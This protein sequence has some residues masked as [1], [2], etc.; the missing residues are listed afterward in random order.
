MRNGAKMW[1][2]LSL[3][4]SNYGYSVVLDVT[5]HVELDSLE[6]EFMV[7]ELKGKLP[8]IAYYPCKII[9]NDIWDVTVSSVDYERVRNHLKDFYVK[10]PSDQIIELISGRRDPN[11]IFSSVFSGT[12][13]N[14]GKEKDLTNM[15]MILT[16]QLVL[17]GHAMRNDQWERKLGILEHIWQKR[18]GN[19]PTTFLVQSTSA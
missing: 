10:Y 19:S 15:L 7:N 17:F 1:K 3:F 6:D 8:L 5:F 9:A 13:S 4:L 18:Y 16:F 14:M 11:R 2:P 12:V